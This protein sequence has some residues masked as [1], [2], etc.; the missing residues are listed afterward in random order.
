MNIGTVMKLYT[1]AQHTEQIH[2]NNGQD[3][4][5]HKEAVWAS[6]DAGLL[7]SDWVLCNWSAEMVM[8]GDGLVS[9]PASPHCTVHTNPHQRFCRN[10]TLP[11]RFLQV[12]ILIHETRFDN[13]IGKCVII[14]KCHQTVSSFGEKS[15]KGMKEEDF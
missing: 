15:T 12:D 3:F 7:S 6:E 11:N 13:A 14:W 2:N 1:K 10:D 9:C 8:V 4:T 5:Q